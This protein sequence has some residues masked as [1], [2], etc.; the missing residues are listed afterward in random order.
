MNTYLK[1]HLEV[2][3]FIRFLQA[4]K[5]KENGIREFYKFV[6]EYV[7]SDHWGHYDSGMFPN[8]TKAELVLFLQGKGAGVVKTTQI[9]HTTSV[10]V[11]NIRKE[12]PNMRYYQPNKGIDQ[13]ISDWKQFTEHLP[14]EFFI[15]WIN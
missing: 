12:Q 14:R 1:F 10:N 13:L 11:S 5:P 9:L 3:C 4:I 7:P 8:V 2:Q 6:E 15:K